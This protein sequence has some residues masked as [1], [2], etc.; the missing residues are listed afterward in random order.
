MR[1]ILQHAMRFGVW[2]LVFMAVFM[3][4]LSFLQRLA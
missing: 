2:V 1:P 3:G 4:L